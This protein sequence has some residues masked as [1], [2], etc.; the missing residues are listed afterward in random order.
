[1]RGSDLESPGDSI[2]AREEL[3]GEA[4]GR[5]HL[6]D[7]NQRRFSQVVA[8]WFAEVPLERRRA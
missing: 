5:G 2:R 4:S 1:M 7:G 3:G 8:R 6:L